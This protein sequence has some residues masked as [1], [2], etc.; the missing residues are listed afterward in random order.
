MPQPPENFVYNAS[1]RMLSWEAIIGADSYWIEFAINDGLDNWLT[2]Y[3][4]PDT[5][6]QFHKPAGIYRTK[7][8]SGDAGTWSLPGKPKIIEI[9]E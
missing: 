2:L 5:I 8:R 9:V 4:G 7:G 3:I 6:C 1:S